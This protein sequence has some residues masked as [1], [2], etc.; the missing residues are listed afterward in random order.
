MPDRAWRQP[1]RLEEGV[2]PADVQAAELLERRCAQVGHD[3]VLDELPVALRR[4]RRD[5]ASGIFGLRATCPHR[6]GPRMPLTM[7]I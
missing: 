7:R 1:P 5:V 4:P 2:P 3:L 6:A